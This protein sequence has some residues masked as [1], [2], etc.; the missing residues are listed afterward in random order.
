MSI[1]WEDTDEVELDVYVLRS[2]FERT[3]CLVKIKLLKLP[4]LVFLG[5]GQYSDFFVLFCFVFSFSIC[6]SA[7]LE[8]GVQVNSGLL[9][10][11]LS[12]KWPS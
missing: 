9:R 3:F 6:L 4:C 7:P 10:D 8:I 2:G 5:K 11:G 1:W 12:S